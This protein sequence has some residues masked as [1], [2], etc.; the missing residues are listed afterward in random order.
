MPLIFEWLL[1]G[2][3]FNKHKQ[4]KFIYIYIYIYITTNLQENTLTIFF[5]K[6]LKTKEIKIFVLK[7]HSYK[8]IKQPHKNYLYM[9]IKHLYTWSSHP[10][11]PIVGY[12]FHLFTF[13]NRSPMALQQNNV[14][15]NPLNIYNIY[16]KNQ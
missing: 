16:T 7:T 6:S 4:Y 8:K 15:P 10:S 3:S 9:T 5:K 11:N 13:Q 14:D 1:I 12:W 2:R